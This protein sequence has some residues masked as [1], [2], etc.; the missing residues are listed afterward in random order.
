MWGILSIGLLDPSLMSPPG[1][2]LTWRRVWWGRGWPPLPW[3]PQHGKE[4]QTEGGV[5]VVR[6]GGGWVGPCRTLCRRL[7]NDAAILIFTSH[8]LSLVDTVYDW[9]LNRT[10]TESHVGTFEPL[11]YCLLPCPSLSIPTS[12]AYISHGKE[13]IV[14]ELLV[15]PTICSLLNTT[16]TFCLVIVCISCHGNV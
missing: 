15:L 8:T 2:F 4:K 12:L 6:R 11:N 16:M 10:I 5:V 13:S 7:P 14:W 9:S 3:K 1:P